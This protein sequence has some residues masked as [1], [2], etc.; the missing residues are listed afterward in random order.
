MDLGMAIQTPSGEKVPSIGAVDCAGAAMMGVRFMT[1]LAK[2]GGAYSQQIGCCGS[3]RVMAKRAIL[4]N[5]RM[6]ADKRAAFF[7]MTDITGVI[8]AVSKH[9]AGASGTM[10]IMTI[11]TNN[12]TFAN[13]MAGR[14]V[15]LCPLFFMTGKTDFC[16]K[17]SIAHFIPGCVNLMASGTSNIAIC[18]RTA[19]PMHSL[20]ALMAIETGTIP[21]FYGIARIPGERTCR[22]WRL[23]RIVDVSTASAM[24]TGTGWRELIGVRSMWRLANRKHRFPA[25]VVT[26][27][28]GLVAAEE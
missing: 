15:D 21:V 5:R 12:L 20:S 18:M 9:F 6:I 25:F 10:R 1:L 16:L 24:T 3:M 11:R 23:V 26:T 27:G 19:G 13:G 8:H 4:L 7:H 28:T 14:P 2:K 17:I 22:H